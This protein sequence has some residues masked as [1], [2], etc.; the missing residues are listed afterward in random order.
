LLFL[1]F[2]LYIEKRG[3][4]LA[5]LFMLDNISEAEFVYP[6]EFIIIIH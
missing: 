2:T 1:Q 3:L 6:F 5:I 4:P